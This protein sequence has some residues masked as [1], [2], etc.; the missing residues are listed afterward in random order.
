MILAVSPL[1][2]AAVQVPSRVE[3]TYGTY[4]GFLMVG[5]TRDEFHHDGGHYHVVSDSRTVGLADLF[6]HLVIHD[7]AAGSVT[8]RGLRPE[9]FSEKQNGKIKFGADFNWSDGRAVLHDGDGGSDTVSLPDN[10]WDLTSFSYNFAFTLPDDKGGN[11]DAYL[12][13]GRRLSH[14]RYAIVGRERLDTA[15]GRLDTVHIRKILEQG[16]NRPFE[17]WLAVNRHYLPVRI[18]FAAKNGSVFD[19][20][21]TRIDTSAQ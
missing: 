15:V 18:R 17:M 6:H 4:Y 20:R 12:V 21:V 2:A 9:T 5:E 14:Y 19:S 16:D 11:L 8:G 13:E 1:P 7:E 10:T 3:V